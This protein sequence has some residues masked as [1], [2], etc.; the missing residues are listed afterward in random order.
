[1]KGNI[2]IYEFPPKL[3][4]VAFVSIIDPRISQKDTIDYLMAHLNLL[5]VITCVQKRYIQKSSPPGHSLCTKET[6][7]NHWLDRK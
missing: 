3:W 1:M 4:I 7:K 2:C 6:S 5:P